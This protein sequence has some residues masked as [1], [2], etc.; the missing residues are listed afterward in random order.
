MRIS[1]IFSVSWGAE[2]LATSD[3][4]SYMESEKTGDGSFRRKQIM[5]VT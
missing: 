5:S 4:Y 1:Q 2:D 3:S